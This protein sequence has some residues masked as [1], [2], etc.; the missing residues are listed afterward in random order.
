M[1]DLFNIKITIHLVNEKGK[2]FVD[3]QG[4]NYGEMMRIFSDCFENEYPLLVDNAYC[5]YEMMDSY[6]Y[7][8]GEITK[9][10]AN[11]KI[12]YAMVWLQKI[13]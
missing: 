10:T 5:H 6:E 12:G 7:F 11:E 3:R 9:V 4:V 13:C 8:I 2:V 1:N